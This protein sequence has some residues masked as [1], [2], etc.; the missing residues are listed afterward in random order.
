MLASFTVV[1]NVGLMLI[2]QDRTFPNTQIG[3]KRI[4]SVSVKSVQAI[5]EET[6]SIPQSVILVHDNQRVLL[7]LHELGF[8]QDSSITSDYVQHARSWL[9]IIDLFKKHALPLPL[10]VDQQQFALTAKREAE[11]FHTRAVSAKVVYHDKAFSTTA[12]IN[13][14]DLDVYKLQGTIT[15]A[16][17]QGSTTVQV[18]VIVSSASAEAN[19]QARQTAQ[20]LQQSLRTPI[21][22]TLAGV[23]YQVNESD[24]ASWYMPSS[25]SFALDAFKIRTYIANVGLKHGARIGNLTDDVAATEQAVAAYKKTDIILKPFAVTKTITYCVSG[26]G[27]QESDLPELKAKLAST[28]ADLR[29]WSLDGQVIFNYATSGCDFTVWLVSPS[30]M[31]TFGAICDS[32][33]DCEVNNNVVVNIDRWFQATPSWNAYSGN[34]SDYRVMLINHETG[35]M[36]GFQHWKCPGSG[37]PAPVMMQESIDLQGCT[38]NIWPTPPELDTLRNKLDL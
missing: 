13:G 8:V 32:Y 4:G 38:F 19:A 24:I 28:Y 25:S 3:S 22:Y 9:P 11:V 36:L 10:R 5:A 15:Q 2:F 1:A 29:G 26:R 21:T 6:S 30:Q 14:Y 33:W 16:L 35:H 34:L 18:P 23:N 20:R 27:V 31:S 37:Q 17:D 7:P 12:P